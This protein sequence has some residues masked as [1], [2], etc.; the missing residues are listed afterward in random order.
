MRAE[1]DGIMFG[2]GSYN[3]IDVATPKATFRGSEA[4]H[5][6]AR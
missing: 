2:G 3:A 6:I 4:N 1:N 5:V